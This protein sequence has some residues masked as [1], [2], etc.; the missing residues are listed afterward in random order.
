MAGACCGNVFNC[1]CGKCA[2]RQRENRWALTVAPGTARYERRFQIDTHLSLS[3]R[4]GNF[5][6]AGA[7]SYHRLFHPEGELGHGA[8][9]KRCGSALTISTFTTTAIERHCR[10][11]RQPFWFQL[12]MQRDRDFSKGMV[13]RA[14]AAGAKVVCLTAEHARARLPLWPAAFHLPA[15]LSVFIYAG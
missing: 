9:S 5:H 15:A 8:R 10:N 4:T 3:L 2:D 1:R 12:Y 11:T 7:D 13:E 6:A 14:V